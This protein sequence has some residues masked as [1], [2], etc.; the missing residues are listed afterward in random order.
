MKLELLGPGMPGQPMY[1]VMPAKAAHAE[2]A[3]KFIALA[4]SPKVQAEGIVSN[5]TGIPASMRK[6]VQTRLDPQMWDK[7]FN[8]VSPDDLASKGRSF[9]ISPYFNDISEA[10][11]RVG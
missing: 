5:S 3:K 8:D 6:Y 7:L 11:R 2:L 4:T 10:T 9:P 1:Y